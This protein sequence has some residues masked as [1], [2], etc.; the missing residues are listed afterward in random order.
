MQE[1][2]M[3][4][5]KNRNDQNRV[6][7]WSEEGRAHAASGT[8][9]KFLAQEESRRFHHNVPAWYQETSV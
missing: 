3:A 4:W 6:I 1:A 2:G 8:F 5:H 9:C 7:M